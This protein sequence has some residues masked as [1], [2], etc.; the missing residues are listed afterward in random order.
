MNLF[1]KFP[2]VRIRQFIDNPAYL[3]FWLSR[4]IFFKK[5]SFKYLNRYSY[6]YP[7]TPKETLTRIIDEKLSIARYGDGEFGILSGAGIYPP[8]SDW[9]QCYSKALR[10]K[11]SNSMATNE[12][13][14][15]KA[16]PSRKLVFSNKEEAKNDG[17]ISS[18]HTE[19]RLFLWRYIAVRQVYGDWGVFTTQHHQNWDWK[20]MSTFLNDKDVVIVTGDVH[21]MSQLSLGKNTFFIETGKHNAF[22]HYDEIRKSILGLVEAKGLKKETTLIMASLGPTAC[23]LALDFTKEGWQVW[24]TG[25]MFKF[26]NKELKLLKE[27]HV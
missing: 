25:H 5:T 17:M 10:E 7:L 19:L 21:K 15:I 8:D 24:D 20:K 14:L 2:I 12:P 16:F 18:M 4:I 9:S 11:L 1:G 6:Y 13:R 27:R 22:E 26:A 23:I 3:L